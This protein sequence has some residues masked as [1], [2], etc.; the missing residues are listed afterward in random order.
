M[1]DDD[2]TNNS[3][4]KPLG[5]MPTNAE[6]VPGAG[7][8]VMDAPQT[9]GRGIVGDI[10]RTIGSHWCQEMKNFNQKTV[11]VTLL[12][13]ISVIAPTLTFGAVYGKVTK[14]KIGAIETIISTGWVGVVYALI[15]GMPLCIMGSTG[16]VLAMSTSLYTMSQDMGIPYLTFN[17]WVS[18]WL[19]F[20]CFLAAFFDITRYVR[21]ATRFTDEIFAL[22]IVSIFVMDA[23]WDPFSTVGIIHFL[24][25]DHASHEKHEDDPDYSYL[26]TGFLSVILGFGTCSLIFFFRSFKTS[27]FFCHD[28]VRSSLHDFAVTLSVIFWTLIKELVFPQVKTETLSVPDT[29]EP[30]FKCCDETCK[31]LFPDD[32]SS[33]T[34]AWGT[35]DW[36]VDLGDLDG[37]AWVPIMAAGPAILAF[38]LCFLDCGITWHLINHKSHKIQHGEAYNYD[39]V[40]NGI[41]NMVNGMLGLPWLVATTVPCIIHLSALA[42]KDERGHIVKVQET[43]LTMLFSH[44]LVALSVVALDALKLLPLPVLYGVFLFMGLS[45]LPNIQMWKRFLLFFQQPSKYPQTVYTQ[46]MEKSRIHKYTIVQICFFAGVFVVMN[47]K[48]ISIAFPFMT[49]LCIPA[50]L[51]LFPK[52]FEGWELV[53]L[54]GDDEQIAE[55]TGAKEDSIRNSH[56]YLVVDVPSTEK[57]LETSSTR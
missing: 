50:R 16:P 40:L 26:T 43:R 45:S 7:K 55:W 38:M 32:C 3:K 10:K 37:K 2:Q 21:L 27:S 39:L 51:F 28:S 42:E 4:A 31:T 57:A 34:E 41:F 19:C 47:V 8:V 14:N 52:L 48:A 49:M 53:V 56:K 35:R 29:V 23:A 18:I 33:Q 5:R 20:Y 24:Y 17:A 44:L 15:G 46:Y 30:T 25:P 6:L 36:F 54:D 13:F 9:W 1:S 11:A 12:V 22:L